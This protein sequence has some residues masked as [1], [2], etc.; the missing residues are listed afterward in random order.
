MEKKRFFCDVS[1]GKKQISVENPADKFLPERH[2]FAKLD[3]YSHNV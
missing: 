3:K 1:S 2:F